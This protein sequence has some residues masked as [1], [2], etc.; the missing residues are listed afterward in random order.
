MF[1]YIGIL[2]VEELDCTPYVV[3]APA[4]TA[5]VGQIVTFGDH[6]GKVVQCA[7]MDPDSEE[8]AIMSAVIQIHEAD[9]LYAPRYVK[10][11]ENAD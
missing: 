2:L 5:E 9:A 10:E 3:K 8:Y 11:E 1:R 4:Y 6:T 7:T